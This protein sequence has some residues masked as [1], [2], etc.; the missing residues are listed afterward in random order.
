MEVDVDQPLGRFAR[1][2]R[3]LQLDFLRTQQVWYHLAELI[4]ERVQL[5]FLSVDALRK[6]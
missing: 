1:Q 4:I 2:L 3:I 6:N 5:R